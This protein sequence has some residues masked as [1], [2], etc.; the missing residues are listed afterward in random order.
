MAAYGVATAV[1]MSQTAAL[2]AMLEQGFK[3]KCQPDDILTT[4]SRCFP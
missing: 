2:T 3:L 1:I 4:R